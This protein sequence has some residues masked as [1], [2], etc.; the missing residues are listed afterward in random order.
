MCQH[1]PTFIPFCIYRWCRPP[2]SE[3]LLGRISVGN[4]VGRPNS[5]TCAKC[6]VFWSVRH[7]AC[8]TQQPDKLEPQGV[9]LP[10]RVHRLPGSDRGDSHTARQ[11]TT[12]PASPHK[13]EAPTE[14]VHRVQRKQYLR[15]LW[16][17]TVTSPPNTRR[18]SR[19]HHGRH[20]S[21]NY[22]T[23]FMQSNNVRGHHG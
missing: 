4:H 9:R 7:T 21:R 18:A 11:S 12:R 16:G 3:E 5:P 19:Q 13:N 2:R 23:Q 8:D 17:S 14:S 22:Q 20:S 15:S 6:R 10:P 1:S